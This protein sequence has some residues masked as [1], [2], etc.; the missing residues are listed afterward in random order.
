MSLL[1]QFISWFTKITT[2]TLL[3]CCAAIKAS[4][5]SEWTT[6]ILWHIPLL[7]FVATII[8]IIIIGNKDYSRREGIIRYAIHFVFLTTAVLILG[9]LFQW[10]KPSFFGCSIMTL[11]VA[12]VYAF[13][14]LANYISSKKSADELNAALERRRN[15]KK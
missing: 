13:T 6:D 7:G 11:Y 5:V 1:K 9:A 10:Y 4:G 8:T 15:E 2:G 14:Y 12:I 3:I